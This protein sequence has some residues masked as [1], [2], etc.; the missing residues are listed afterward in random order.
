MSKE[1][2][3]VH[4]TDKIYRAELMRQLLEEE[5]IEAVIINKKDS[6]YLI[7]EIEVYTR[8]DDV[9]KAKLLIEKFE[10]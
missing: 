2:I 6:S 8:P 1:W 3:I 7:G 10:L 9:M 5:G 4:T